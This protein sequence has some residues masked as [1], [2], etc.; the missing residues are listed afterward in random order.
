MKKIL[1]GTVLTLALSI[2]CGASSIVSLSHPG[3][4][5]GY[6]CPSNSASNKPY[7]AKA[8]KD[9]KSKDDGVN[10][11]K[12]AKPEPDKQAESPKATQ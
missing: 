11:D 5:Y 6:G 3:P 8:T 10:A 9:Q 12:N 7:N 1:A 2:S 4:C